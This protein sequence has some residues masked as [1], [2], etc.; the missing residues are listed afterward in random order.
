M[1]A[2]KLCFLDNFNLNPYSNRTCFPWG[3][4]FCVPDIL[5]D[6]N[7]VQIEN[8]CFSSTTI[9]VNSGS[10]EKSNLVC[11]ETSVIAVYYF[12]TMLPFIFWAL[13]TI[14]KFFCNVIN[15][16]NLIIYELL[17]GC[18]WEWKLQKSQSCPYQ[19]MK[20]KMFCV[21]NCDSI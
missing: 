1:T 7:P 8:I 13:N 21:N 11:I 17:M 4:S 10:S 15:D 9:A 5:C 16:L 20:S 18:K 2:F 19:Y 6:L 3:W 14:A 12:F